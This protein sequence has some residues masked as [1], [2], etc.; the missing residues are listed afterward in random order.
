MTIK[1][2]TIEFLDLYA[3]HLKNLDDED[4]YT[5]FGYSAT[6]AT[7]D[8]LILNILYNQ[9][10]HHIFTY[11]VEGK[12]LGFGHLAK[13][14]TDW[15]LAVSVEKSF[16][17]QGIA[18]SLMSHMISW[19]KTHGVNA[20]YMHC[21]TENQRIQ[22]LAKKHGLK[23]IDRSGRDIT[24]QVELPKPTIVDYATELYQEQTELAKDIVRLQKTWLKNWTV[25]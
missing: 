11:A 12:I 1:H 6:P 22:H 21:I 17:G 20:V 9:D 13:D 19:G 3:Q 4:R 7:I 16:Q 15:E 5:R 14:G 23:T 10:N 25:K 24:A 8:S 18:D 2:S